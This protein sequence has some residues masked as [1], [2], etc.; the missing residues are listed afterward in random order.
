MN[1]SLSVH[2]IVWIRFQRLLGG[3]CSTRFQ[4]RQSQLPSDLSTIILQN[5]HCSFKLINQ[6][7]KE[8]CF[9]TNPLPNR[10]T[11]NQL[12]PSHPPQVTSGRILTT[13]PKISVLIR[14]TYVRPLP[15]T[16]NRIPMLSRYPLRCTLLHCRVDSTRLFKSIIKWSFLRRI[17][18]RRNTH[19]THITQRLN[20]CLFNTRRFSII[21]LIT[22][23][24]T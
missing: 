22:Q 18:R 2:Q 11:H 13:T 3:N 24:I 12:S 21:R 6:H 7:Q 8:E 1:S 9:A 15:K 4:S 10:I 17:C 19:I 5:Y 14:H 16:L 20:T 23:A